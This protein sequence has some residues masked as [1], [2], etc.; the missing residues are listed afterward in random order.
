MKDHNVFVRDK[1]GGQEIQ[2]ST[3]GVEGNAY[4]MLSWAPDS[5][6]LVAWRIEPGDDKEVYLVESS[7]TAADGPSSASGPIPCRAT[8]SQTYELNLF[9]VETT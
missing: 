7:P 1:N 8:S 5:K 9:D 6:T 4:G 2:L 3:D